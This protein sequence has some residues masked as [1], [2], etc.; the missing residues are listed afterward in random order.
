MTTTARRIVD[1]RGITVHARAVKRW[2]FHWE[3]RDG[4]M[5]SDKNVQECDATKVK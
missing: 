1:R 2:P 4:P 5:S 3:G